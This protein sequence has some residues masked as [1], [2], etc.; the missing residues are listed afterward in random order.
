M[1][2]GARGKGPTVR[3]TEAQFTALLARAGSTK[4]AV[5]LALRDH[6]V[7]GRSMSEAAQF[8]DV[9]RSALYDKLK[10]MGLRS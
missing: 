2:R 5:R 9:D 4:L 7:N 1:N 10:R 3:L 8:R 6:L